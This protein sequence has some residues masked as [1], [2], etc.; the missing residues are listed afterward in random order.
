M[1]FMVTANGQRWQNAIGWLPYLLSGVVLM[2]CIGLN[3]SYEGVQARSGNRLPLDALTDQAAV[4]QTR[5]LVLHYT[6]SREGDMLRIDGR[7]ERLGPI[8]NFDI[9]NYLR[10]AIHFIDAEG[11]I[12]DSKR[13]WAADVVSDTRLVRWT[14]ARRYRLPP[15]ASAFGF[16]YQGAVSGRGANAAGRSGWEVRQ[17]P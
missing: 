11:F 17:A 10:V 1:A 6:A 14:F 4:W 2:G 8:K 13:L 12:V 7:V 5:D 9:I 16:S 3:T 15:R